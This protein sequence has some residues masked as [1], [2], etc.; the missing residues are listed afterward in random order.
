MRRTLK[1]P[2]GGKATSEQGIAMSSAPRKL[3]VAARLGH[4]PSYL[5]LLHTCDSLRRAYAFHK[6]APSFQ[7]VRGVPRRAEGHTSIGRLAKKSRR[8]L[9]QPRKSKLDLSCFLGC[10]LLP[11]S[12]FIFLRFNG[13]PISWQ[14]VKVLTSKQNAPKFCRV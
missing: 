8:V 1:N 4:S 7:S 9:C 12:K 3:L 14:T 5:L 6:T 2:K 11:C 13:Q 10:F